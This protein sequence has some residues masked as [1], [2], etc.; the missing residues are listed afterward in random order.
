[1]SDDRREGPMIE[2]SCY[3]CRYETHERYWVQGD[4]GSD[5][6]CMHSSVTG[7]RSIGDSI[8]RTPEWCPLL[9]I[10]VEHLVAS[11]ARTP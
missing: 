11:R 5:V 4:S 6:S 8:W 9:T 2:M 7:D 1:M 3:G 10:A